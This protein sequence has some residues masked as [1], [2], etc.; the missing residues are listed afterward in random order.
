[1]SSEKKRKISKENIVYLA[2]VLLILA[3]CTA[4]YLSAGNT[5]FCDWWK[6]NVFKPYT[7]LASSI[8]AGSKT[9]WGLKIA[10]VLLLYLFG[11]IVTVF[12]SVVFRTDS[13]KRF[14]NRYLKSVF[15]IFLSIVFLYEAMWYIPR[16]ATLLN[17]SYALST[18]VTGEDLLQLNN[19]L[20]LEI[21]DCEQH[22]DYFSN[23]E[24]N[25]NSNIENIAAIRRSV[26]NL[27][28]EFPYLK[29][30]CPDA[31]IHSNSLLETILYSHGIYS[32]TL[33]LTGEMYMYSN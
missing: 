32:F 25:P 33:P 21:R 22:L 30:E 26:K 2:A 23:G 31:K 10:I 16:N 19:Y 20:N 29:G 11:M 13:Y 24:V 15:V 7:D 14:R 12:F 1:M 5:A 18:L 4:A 17:G 3:L 6:L 8:T 28:T 9:S 27:S